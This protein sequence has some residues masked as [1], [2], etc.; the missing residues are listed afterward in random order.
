MAPSIT[1]RHAGPDDAATIADLH[2]DAWRVA[3]RGVIDDEVLDDPALRQARHDGW[4]RRL[5]D[6]PPPDGDTENELFAG[7][8]DG[9]VVGFGHAG[10]EADPVTGADGAPRFPAGGEI[11]G[12]YLHPDAWGS[13][14]A[15]ALMD[16]CM[17]HLRRRFVHGVLW[18][19]RDNPRARGFYERHGWSCGIGADVIEEGW[20]GPV[21]PGA[22]A[23]PR[24]VASLQYRISLDPS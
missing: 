13:G 23:L 2:T 18:V 19:L 17:T 11:Y 3:Y 8:I 10:R 24:P 15:D 6:G 4:N 12:F 14:V 9:R 21:M 20:A 7:L 22:P 1:T 5:R 16:A